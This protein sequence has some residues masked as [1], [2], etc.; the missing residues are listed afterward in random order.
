M[1]HDRVVIRFESN[2]HKVMNRRVPVFNLDMNKIH[3]DHVCVA[4]SVWNNGN[5]RL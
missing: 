1:H 2:L 4:K 3:V 5:L